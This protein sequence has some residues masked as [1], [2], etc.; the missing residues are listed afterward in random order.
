MVVSGGLLIL[1]LALLFERVQG[2][3]R[4]YLGRSPGTVFLPAIVLT[5]VFAA[6]AAGEGAF[7]VP[8]TLLAA[9]YTLLP[10]LC[11]A[12]QRKA[13]RQP[14]LLDLVG[15]LLLWLPLEFAAGASL[16]PREAQGRLH[17]NAYGIA[18]LLALLLFLVIRGLD[19]LRYRLPKR[20]DC[21]NALAGFLIAAATLIPL[22]IWVGFLNKPHPLRVSAGT[23]VIRMAMILLGTA[24]PEEILFRGLIQNW[25]AQRLGRPQPAI[26]V[27]ALIFGCAHLN[28]APGPLPNWRY[29]I[30]A[31]GAGLIFGEVFQASASIFASALTHMGVNTVKYLFL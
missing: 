28:N 3:L 29:A 30:V 1:I 7:S 8:L 10:T 27:A 25:L 4:L 16:V 5:A 2:W 26:I 15:I 21:R 23:A 6:A 11:V 17:A 31:T 24:L 20:A 14:S 22:G 12:V 9:C 13:S 19:G 18:I